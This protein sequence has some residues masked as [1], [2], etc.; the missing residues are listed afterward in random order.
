M[1]K[2]QLIIRTLIVLLNRFHSQ[3]HLYGHIILKVAVVTTM[4]L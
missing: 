2:I 4:E 3:I 1:D